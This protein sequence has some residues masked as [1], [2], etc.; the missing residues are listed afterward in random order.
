MALSNK[1]SVSQYLTMG[2]KMFS[3]KEI[4]EIVDETEYLSDGVVQQHYYFFNKPKQIAAKEKLAAFL[5]EHDDVKGLKEHSKST[6]NYIECIDEQMRKDYPF[7]R[8]CRYS[9]Y[10]YMATKEL[11]F[12]K[13]ISDVSETANLSN[14]S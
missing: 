13:N 9:F 4:S 14:V 12:R 8:P 2:E 1:I 5:V 11:C 6:K 3:K 10:V 7:D